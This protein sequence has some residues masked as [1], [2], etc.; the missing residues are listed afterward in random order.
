MSRA[1]ATIGNFRSLERAITPGWFAIVCR[2]LSRYLFVL[3]LCSQSLTLAALAETRV[4]L[5]IGISAYQGLPELK[6]PRNDAADVADALRQQ[7]FSVIYGEDLDQAA[8]TERITRFA[9]RVRQA[10]VALFYFAGHGFQIDAQNYLVPADA[11]V[12]DMAG[13]KRATIDLRTVLQAL[14]GTRGLRLVILDACRNNPLPQSGPEVTVGVRDGLARIGTGAN[15]HFVFAT[16]P[17]KVAYDGAGRNSPFTGALLS[18]IATRGQDLAS[19]LIKVRRDVIAATGGQQVPW[20]SSS[21]TRPFAFHPGTPETVSPEVQLWQLGATQRDAALL[22]LYIDRFPS[23]AHI[24]EARALLEPMRLASLD[25]GSSRSAG[26]TAS[27]DEL[28]SLVIRV[29]LRP[30]ANYYLQR[31][32]NGRHAEDAK[33]LLGTLADVAQSDLPAALLCE[34]LA[35]HPRDATAGIDGVPLEILLRQVERAVTA[36]R[37]A[38][39]DHPEHSHYQAL[40]ARS[41]W[42]ALQRKEALEFYRIAADRGN[43]RALV[44]LGLI[45]ESGEGVSKDV[46]GALALYERAANGGSADG[47]INLAV[48][49]MD[50]QVLPRNVPRA[51]QLLTKAAQQGSAIATYNLGVLAEKGVLDKRERAL[52]HFIRAVELGDV[53]G[54]RAAAV[55]LDEGRGTRKDPETAADL[56]LRAAAADTGEVISELTRSSKDW[57]TA[58]ISALQRRL[59]REGFYQ[60]AIDGRSGP[61]LRQPLQRW[62]ETGSITTRNG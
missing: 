43:L 2:Q 47:A 22:R 4:A 36:C 35:T 45:L 33:R 61:K 23:G 24:S 30:L 58:T 57:S 9:A 37:S 49:L 7:G 8:M 53:R 10:D 5:V 32:P 14:E 62:R 56:L 34:R 21:L 25:A 59:Q 20:D 28:W 15:F 52:E 38:V 12:R 13:I 50:G 3:T 26:N 31:Y 39:A 40:L 6:N 17:D 41:L 42:A 16:E 1:N 19:M 18:H 46:R 55:L 27:E 48:A 11:I 54:N 51:I 60:G 44:S 29:R